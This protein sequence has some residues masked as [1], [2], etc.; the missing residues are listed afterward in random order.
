MS[1]WTHYFYEWSGCVL[2]G[3]E[4]SEKFWGKMK[5]LYNN[6][7]NNNNNNN[8]KNISG[9]SCENLKIFRKILQKLNCNFQ[10]YDASN[11][12]KVGNRISQKQVEGPPRLSHRDG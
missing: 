2:I 9:K 8:L 11:A 10:L 12:S 5:K 6:N 1:H 7:N 3:K 4:K